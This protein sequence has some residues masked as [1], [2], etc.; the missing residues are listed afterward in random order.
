MPKPTTIDHPVEM[1]LFVC[2]LASA[3]LT[4][5]NSNVAGQYCFGYKLV[6]PD[7][8]PPTEWSAFR[9]PSNDDDNDEY[10]EDIDMTGSPQ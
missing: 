8:D 5:V 6:V 3:D 1:P 4:D 2:T 10:A 7:V 9:P